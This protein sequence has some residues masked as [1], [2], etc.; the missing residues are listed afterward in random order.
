MVGTPLIA[1]PSSTDVTG[2]IKLGIAAALDVDIDV[3]SVSMV[4]G[5]VAT[6]LP[7]VGGFTVSELE[8]LGLSRTGSVAIV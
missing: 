2:A 4:G 3:V 5:S 8:D 1:V 7:I 6:V